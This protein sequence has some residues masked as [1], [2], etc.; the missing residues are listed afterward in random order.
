MKTSR[1]FTL[2][3]LL[4]VIAIIAILAAMLLPALNKARQKAKQTSCLNKVKQTGISLSSYAVDNNG[5]IPAYDA[6]YYPG[7][8]IELW[9]VLGNNSKYTPTYPVTLARQAQGYMSSPK[10]LIC[11]AR[12]YYSEASAAIASYMYRHWS[13]GYGP[14][15]NVAYALSRPV[16]LG[17]KL[18]LP[19]SSDIQSNFL[20][21]DSCTPHSA[22]A[23]TYAWTAPPHPGNGAN[24]VFFDGHAKFIAPSPKWVAIQGNVGN[25]LAWTIFRANELGLE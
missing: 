21:S 23:K 12:E 9:G 24:V 3:E 6:T 4:V 25:G 7:Q 2:I 19:A 13:M 17:M 5:I 8:G 18:N 1:Y 16:K 15:Y 10:T 22:F 14:S 11:D 20:L